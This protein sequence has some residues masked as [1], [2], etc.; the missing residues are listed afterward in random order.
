MEDTLHTLRKDCKKLMVELDLDH[1]GAE[2]F[3]AKEI[4]TEE[5]RVNRNV[6]NMALTGYRSTPRSEELLRRLQRYLLSLKLKQ[7]ESGPSTQPLGNNTN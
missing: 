6:L 1:Q 3:L 7:L 2:P 5:D 4:S